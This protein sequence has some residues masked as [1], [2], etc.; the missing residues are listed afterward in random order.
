[1]VRGDHGN[2]KPKHRELRGSTRT[3]GDTDGKS[4]RIHLPGSFLDPRCVFRLQPRFRLHMFH[5]DESRVSRI[6]YESATPSWPE[7]R[8]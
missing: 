8:T 4:G 3:T 6:I 1:M 5:I 2:E 7:D